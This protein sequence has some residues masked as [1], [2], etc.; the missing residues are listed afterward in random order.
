M[1]QQRQLMNRVTLTDSDS[2]STLTYHWS[3]ASPH[4]HKWHSASTPWSTAE[5]TPYSTTL[6]T[7]SAKKPPQLSWGLGGEKGKGRVGRK[8]RVYCSAQLFSW[9]AA[10]VHTYTRSGWKHRLYTLHD[11]TNTNTRTETVKESAVIKT[12]CDCDKRANANS[13][14]Q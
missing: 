12:N 8:G 9:P 1:E 10:S 5:L 6:G 13:L 4:C 7:Q 3:T 11:V 2:D 14:V